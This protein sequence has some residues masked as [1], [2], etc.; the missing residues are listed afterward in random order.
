MKIKFVP[1]PKPEPGTKL[2]PRDF[3]TLLGKIPATCVLI[4]GQAVAW[5][6]ERY[7]IRTTSGQLVDVNSKDIDFWGKRADLIRIAELLDRRPALPGKHELTGLVGALEILV[8][9]RRTVLE[10]LHRVPGLDVNNPNAVAV[11]QAITKTGA[12]TLIKTPTLQA[13]LAQSS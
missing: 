3:D 11:P 12:E 4:G 2:K 9:G 10:L 7:S 1:V 6:A 13:R 5:W 8:S